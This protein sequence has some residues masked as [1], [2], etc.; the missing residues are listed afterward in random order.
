M[1]TYVPSQTFSYENRSWPSRTIKS[2][3]VWC[4]VDLR[5]GNQALA[6]PMKPGQKMVF[7]RQL[8]AMGFKEIEVSFPAASK[9]DFDFTRTIIEDGV[10]PDDCAIQIL[11][12]A[13]PALIKRSFEAING[14]KKI[15]LHVYN[16]TSPAQREIV[17]HKSR[18][19]IISIAVDAVR[20]I[21]DL[22][23]AHGSSVTLEYSPESFSQT[24]IDFAVEICNR[25]VETWNP[26]DN[27]KVIINLPSTVEVTT[28][29]V[30]ADQI[31]Y[32]IDNFDRRDRIV[33]SV[34]TH[35]DRGC[36]VAAAEMA[37]LAGADRIEGTLFG[38]GERTG[39]AD[40]MTLALNLYSQGIDPGIDI[41]DIMQIRDTF[42]TC[43]SMTVPPRHPYAGELVFTAFSGSHQDAISKGL[44]HYK[45]V[46]GVWNIP[47]LPVDPADIGRSYD[48]VIRINSQ[49]GKGGAAFIMESVFGFQT[50]KEFCPALGAAVQK[51]ADKAGRELTNDEVRECYYKTFM[52][53]PGPFS[54]VNF[55]VSPVSN[56]TDMSTD[57]SVSLSIRLM[58]D[59]S[60]ITLSGKGNGS[61]DAFSNALKSHG[62]IFS[63]ES[64]HEHNIGSGSDAKAAAYIAIKN[65]HGMSFYGAGVDTDIINASL[66]A[67]ISSVNRM[68]SVR[69]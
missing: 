66:K 23:S 56:D 68:V 55:T 37:L 28:P 36:A 33:T 43:T 35:N 32:M 15:I 22:S 13:R 39:N 64:Y 34:H 44:T 1:T 65:E 62:V 11:T 30:F 24:E 19:E 42:E 10:I 57:K 6:N 26:V 18:S 16:S 60:E 52:E 58:C 21:R 40:L 29:N 49:S 20:Q 45:K 50:P 9:D 8:V 5:D 25:V 47:Y 53:N 63:L 48:A 54:I 41:S 17:F 4:S 31:E 51:E 67:L 14:A 38:N 69:K 3:P 46:G 27:E 7:F 2:K 59:K 12:Q 61:I